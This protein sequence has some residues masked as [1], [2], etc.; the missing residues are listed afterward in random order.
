MMSLSCK[1]MGATDCDYVAKGETTQDVKNNMMK[2][3]MSDHKDMLD[4]MSKEERSSMMA[5]M[6]M[7]VKNQM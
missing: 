2:H 1:D 4:K 6:D 3:A 7:A 5:K